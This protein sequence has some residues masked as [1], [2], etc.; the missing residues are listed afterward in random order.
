M[1]LRGCCLVVESGGVR[2]LFDFKTEREARGG[3]R[4]EGDVLALR[5][6]GKMVLGY[7]EMRE[8]DERQ[9]SI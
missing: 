1:R 9:M 8:R 7:R 3:K 5:N 2:V 6:V 4:R